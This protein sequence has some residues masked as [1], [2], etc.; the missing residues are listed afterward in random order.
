[1]NVGAHATEMRR[2]TSVEPVKE[3]TFT[4]GCSTSGSPTSPPEPM[5]T[6]KTPAGSP[7]SSNTRASATTE[8]GVSVAGLITIVLPAIRAAM[9]FQAGIAIGKFQGVTNAQTPTGWR[10]HMANLFGSSDGVVNPKSRRPS[11]AARKAMSIASW[12]S[13]RVSAST[14]PISRVMRRASFS[15]SRFRISPAA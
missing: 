7:A 10:T 6:L 5:T 4:S 11:P 8:A 14:L 1:M 2:P 13:P 3:T 15:L 9:D 12:T